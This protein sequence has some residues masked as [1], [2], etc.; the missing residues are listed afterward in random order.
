MYFEL[1]CYVF[2]GKVNFD[3]VTESLH[4]LQQAI[5]LRPIEKIEIKK[6]IE[7]NLKPNTKIAKINEISSS[8]KKNNNKIRNKSTPT[9]KSSS[10]FTQHFKNISCRILEELENSALNTTNLDDNVHY[11]PEFISFLLEK[12]MPYCFIW[13]GFVIR[14]LND[15]N[16]RTRFTSGTIEKHFA[17]RKGMGSF[18][19]RLLPEQ[20]ASKAYQLY[21]GNCKTFMVH[22][23]LPEEKT[24]DIES[25]DEEDRLSAREKWSKKLKNIHMPCKSKLSYQQSTELNLAGINRVAKSILKKAKE[26]KKKK[27]N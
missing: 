6:L 4:A 24:S 8:P 5:S 13:S 17:S 11:F 16:L 18:H 23:Q 3:R 27:N 26:Y 25:Q 10:P 14:D 7:T 1:I 19:N 20:Y 22:N 2:L 12:Y 15:T 9:I 21:I